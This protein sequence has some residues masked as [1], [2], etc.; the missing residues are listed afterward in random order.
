MADVVGRPIFIAQH[1]QEVV[2][3]P[4]T[5]LPNFRH[6]PAGVGFARKPPLFMKDGYVCE[7]EVEGIGLPRNSIVDERAA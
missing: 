5:P 4:G 3:M 1:T 2:S 7:I 6:A